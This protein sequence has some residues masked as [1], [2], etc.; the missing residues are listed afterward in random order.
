MLYIFCH[1]DNVHNSFLDELNQEEHLAIRERK[2]PD[3]P[4]DCN[5]YKFISFTRVVSK[6]EISNNVTC[7]FFI[8]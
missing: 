5:D 6:I 3:V 2:K 1:H 7:F 8:N 4:I